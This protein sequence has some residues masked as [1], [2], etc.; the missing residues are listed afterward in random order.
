M[1][2]R[3]QI[4]DRALVIHRLQIGLRPAPAD[5]KKLRE[6]QRPGRFSFHL[7]LGV[8]QNLTLA[9]H[10]E[11]ELVLFDL[12]RLLKTL[13][14]VIAPGGHPLASKRGEFVRPEGQ[15]AQDQECQHRRENGNVPFHGLELVAESG[16][17]AG[18]EQRANSSRNLG[19][20]G[21][22]KFP[23]GRRRK[24]FCP[25]LPGGGSLMVK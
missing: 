3:Q 1:V 8:K 22:V 15:T 5:I 16:G 20:S 6:L 18:P 9:L 12:Q 19:K 13:P 24:D 17:Q 4:D 11:R 25:L 7:A 10:L 23:G 2:I 21:W 14:L